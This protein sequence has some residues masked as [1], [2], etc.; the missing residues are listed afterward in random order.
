M[1]DDCRAI[2]HALLEYVY[3]EL[4]EAQRVRVDRH[5]A[6]CPRCSEDLQGYCDTLTLIDD[7]TLEPSEELSEHFSN[8]V[9]AILARRAS[10]RRTPA[11]RALAAACFAMFV[12]GNS[13][14]LTLEGL[15]RMETRPAQFSVPAQVAELDDPLI[16]ELALRNFHASEQLKRTL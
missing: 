4:D 13:F 8:V 12:I 9:V 15:P 3:G 1:K 2:G 16:R 5:L 6:Q 14:H 7:S 11:L 10:D